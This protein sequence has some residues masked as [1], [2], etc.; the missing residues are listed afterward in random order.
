MFETPDDP[1]LTIMRVLLGVVY[2]PHGAQKLLG[3]FGG[4][5]F[6]GTMAVLARMGIPALF[7]SL[8]ILVEFF[9]P[10]ALILGCLTRLAALAIAVDMLVAVLLIQHSRW[11]LHE[12]VQT[13]KGRGF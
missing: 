7:A 4:G 1:V 5:G 10:L 6:H 8:V 13:A 11:I 3:W 2:F 12:L 9:G